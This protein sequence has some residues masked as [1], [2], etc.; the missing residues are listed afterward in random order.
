MTQQPY[1]LVVNPALPVRTLPELIALARQKPG[2]LTYGSSGI[3]GFSHLA[4]ALFSSLAKLHA[5]IVR[6]LQLPQTRERLAADGSEPVGSSSAEFGRHIHNEIVRW[7]NL[8]RELG[9]KGE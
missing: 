9:I 6:V 5:E 3:G 1:V 8:I 7:R 4:G 2:E